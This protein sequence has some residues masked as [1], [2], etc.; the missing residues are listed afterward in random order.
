MSTQ[1]PDE[2]Y[3]R[4]ETERLVLR[5][6]RMKDTDFVFTAHTVTRWLFRC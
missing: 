5:A 6:L 4:L 1:S 2:A 3:P